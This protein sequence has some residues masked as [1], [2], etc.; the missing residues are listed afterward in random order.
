MINIFTGIKIGG[1]CLL[2]VV[3]FYFGLNLRSTLL[4]LLANLSRRKSNKITQSTKTS[5]ESQQTNKVN[6]TNS[7][8]LINKFSVSYKPNNEGND[9]HFSIFEDDDNESLDNINKLKPENLTQLIL[10]NG[11]LDMGAGKIAAQI[12]H[13]SLGLYSQLFWDGSNEQRE[14]LQAW[15]ETNA[16]KNIYKASGLDKIKQIESILK[17]N[18]IYTKMIADAGR[19]QIKAGSITVMASMP[20]PLNRLNE[21]LAITVDDKDLKDK[22]NSLNKY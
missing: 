15:D 21:L 4:K 2:W 18:K 1:I 7:T 17:K 8:N 6:D 20:I 16:K 3:G 11:E 10:V 13:A 12:A 14:H 19:T 9:E 22:N 5:N